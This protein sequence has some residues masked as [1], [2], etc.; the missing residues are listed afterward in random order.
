MTIKEFNPKTF[1]PQGFIVTNEKCPKCGKTNLIQSPSGVLLAPCYEC[2]YKT[3]NEKSQKEIENAFEVNAMTNAFKGFTWNEYIVSSKAQ[4]NA[5]QTALSYAQGYSRGEHRCLLFV[6]LQ[7]T[8][9]TCLAHLIKRDLLHRGIEVEYVLADDFYNEYLNARSAGFNP[10]LVIQKY[11][12]NDVLIIDEIGRT[13]T[14]DAAANVFFKIIEKTKSSGKG[15]ILLSNASTNPDHQRYIGKYIDIDRMR[16]SRHWEK[17]N[18][19]W[20]TFRK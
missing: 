7:G 15:L 6:G 13:T 10:D 2:E 14:S 16:D 11:L 19:S 3:Q 8:G 1:L 4:E 18:F 5:K 20:G 17:V 9:K 12:F